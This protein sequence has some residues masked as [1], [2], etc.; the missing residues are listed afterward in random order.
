MADRA[1]GYGRSGAEEP[2]EP[3]PPTTHPM[4]QGHPVT[5]VPAATLRSWDEAEARLFPLVMARPDEYERSLRLIQA[6]QA[7]LRHEAQDIPAL[8][9][10]A[11]RGADLVTEV[12]GPGDL[13]VA[14]AGSRLELIAAAACAMRYRELVA[15]L[16]AASRRDAFA[17]ARAGAATGGGSWAVVEEIGDIARA[18]YLPYQRVEAHVGT[19]RAVLIAIEP[20]ETLSGSIWRLDAA[21]LDPGSGRLAIGEPIGSYSSA[22]DCDAALTRLR[23]EP[24]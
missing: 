7:R 6:V 23:E 8:L 10:Q 16:A 1:S 17:R 14:A 5:Q 3:R 12:A 24:A 2:G 18:P 13:G 22:A 4:A 15:G 11:G 9:A 20:D 19:G 21:Q